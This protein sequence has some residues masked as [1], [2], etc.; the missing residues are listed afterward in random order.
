MGSFRN[1]CI[2]RGGAWSRRIYNYHE[3]Y[4]VSILLPAI[5][6]LPTSITRQV[7]L[8]APIAVFYLRQLLPDIG[9][10]FLY[11]GCDFLVSPIQ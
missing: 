8:L 7:S 4:I 3:F 11:L 6:L 10:I 2:S 5:S 9:G 1:F